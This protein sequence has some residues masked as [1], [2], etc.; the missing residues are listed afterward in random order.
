M[1]HHAEGRVHLRPVVHIGKVLVEHG[2]DIDQDV[3]YHHHEKEP[4]IGL[5]R[6]I[7]PGELG[8]IEADDA[9]KDQRDDQGGHVD[10][11][12]YVMIVSS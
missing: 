6:I 7:G 3:G 2:K 8:D 1:Q 12:L 4:L 11:A 5:L 10:Q 9:D